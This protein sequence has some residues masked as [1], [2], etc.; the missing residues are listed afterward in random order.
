MYGSVYEISQSP[1]YVVITYEIV[2]EARVIPLGARARR[3]RDPR[4]HGRHAT[5]RRQ[6]ARRRD[7]ELHDADGVST[8]IPSA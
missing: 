3:R 2:H 1:G 7:D 6:H 8:R 4:T 5:L